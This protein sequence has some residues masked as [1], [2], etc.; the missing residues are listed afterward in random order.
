MGGWSNFKEVRV[1]LFEE[2]YFKGTYNI[3]RLNIMVKD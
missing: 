3:G 1:K 2:E